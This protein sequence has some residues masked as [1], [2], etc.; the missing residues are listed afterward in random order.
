M[1]AWKHPPR[2][3]KPPLIGHPLFFAA[4][5]A[6]MAALIAIAIGG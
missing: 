3:H 4:L 6:A 5:V 1:S 2:K